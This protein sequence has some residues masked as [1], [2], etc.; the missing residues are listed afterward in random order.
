LIE[1][2]QKHEEELVELED[3]KHLKIALVVPMTSL[4]KNL[5][6]VFKGIKNLKSKFWMGQR[7]KSQYYDS[8]WEIE[9]Y[10]KERVLANKIFKIIDTAHAKVKKHHK[11]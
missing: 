1:Q 8:P 10:S 4:R 3:T 5:Q 7:I 2:Q 11:K 9:A 6:S